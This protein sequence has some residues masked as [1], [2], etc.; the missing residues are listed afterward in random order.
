MLTSYDAAFLGILLASQK[1]TPEAVVS[2]RCAFFI[3][4]MEVTDP[5]GSATE[6]SAALAVSLCF[7]KI[8]DKQQDRGGFFLSRLEKAIKPALGRAERILESY[9][10][11]RDFVSRSL[12]EQVEVERIKTGNITAYAS[13]TESFASLLLRT[14]A[15]VAGSDQNSE[16]LSRIGSHIGR[17]LYIVDSCADVPEDFKKR[18]FN[19][20][21]AAYGDEKGDFQAETG[22]EISG[23]LLQSFHEIRQLLPQLFLQRHREIIK[24]ILLVGFPRH[25]GHRL[26]KSLKRIERDRPSLLRYVPHA[27]VISA[28]CLIDNTSA[29]AG[30]VSGEEAGHGCSAYGYVLCCENES[31]GA[32]GDCL[33]LESLLNPCLYTFATGDTGPQGSNCCSNL[34]CCVLQAPKLLLLLIPL[35]FAFEIG[36]E[37]A[38]PVA[39][40]IKRVRQW[41]E[42][43]RAAR[44]KS[45]DDKRV[46]ENAAYLE[47]QTSDI[48]DLAKTMDDQ[49]AGVITLK[50]NQ[51][52][53]VYQAF[54]KKIQRLVAGKDKI[55]Y[56]ISREI[57][58]GVRNL[59]KEAED[60]NVE[61]SATLD[62][63]ERVGIALA[64]IRVLRS[65]T[66]AC[67]EQ[68][69]RFYE[70]LINEDAFAVVFADRRFSDY[71]NVAE[72]ILADLGSLR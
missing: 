67:I 71:R 34:I 32:K 17:I 22:E 53:S 42:D 25:I 72:K 15:K 43:Q 55:R 61:V 41:I 60:L 45:R 21:Q 37:A 5:E 16:V 44:I 33:C 59:T 23:I 49:L 57:V 18:E 62:I 12:K 58:E 24:D 9:E 36:S 39:G 11:P 56:R 20:L 68:Q 3:K 30:W 48:R 65:G 46:Q 13:P 54:D 50:R 19:S 64:S 38:G 70:A 35:G 52:S 4:K 8:K 31:C 51:I 1:K 2:G 14:T 28:M 27:A 47:S 7:A 40:F 10:I 69:L 26:T 29:Y 63:K 66:D 6:I